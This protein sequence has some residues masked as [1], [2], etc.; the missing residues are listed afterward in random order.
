MATF[1]LSNISSLNRLKRLLAQKVLEKVPEERGEAQTSGNEA[2]RW[3]LRS[4]RAS[5][6]TATARA[7]ATLDGG[8][9]AL[10]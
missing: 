6:S 8:I 7:G 9:W 5:D 1:F 10:G 4:G 3:T 2:F